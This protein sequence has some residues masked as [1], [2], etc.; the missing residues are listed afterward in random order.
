MV[1]SYSVEQ[2]KDFAST[3]SQ[4]ID[5][6][7]TSDNTTN[8]SC[9]KSK[10]TNYRV[11]RADNPED[12]MDE[13][14]IIIEATVGDMQ[15]DE[16]GTCFASVVME[17][18]DQGT[19]VVIAFITLILMNKSETAADFEV[20]SA[21]P[22]T[23]NDVN[24][25]KVTT[26]STSASLKTDEVTAWVISADVKDIDV[27]TKEGMSLVGEVTSRGLSSETAKSIL[28]T[29]VRA[30][31]TVNLGDSKVVSYG[32]KEWKYPIPYSYQRSSDATEVRYSGSNSETGDSVSIT[33]SSH[34]YSPWAGTRASARA[35]RILSGKE[36]LWGSSTLPYV[37]KDSQP[38]NYST[39]LTNTKGDISG[40]VH[41]QLESQQVSAV[42]FI[43][44]SDSS[45]TAELAG[46]TAARFSE[47]LRIQALTKSNC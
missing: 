14:I 42:P 34:K 28:T 27:D 39:L 45:V 37:V 36:E 8:C 2:S 21:Q 32:T 16:K 12:S 11:L 20:V 3:I 41:T 17:V 19:N 22:I 30:V 4:S 18:I 10:L 47:I 33:D 7:K 31:K 1:Q 9:C 46:A 13:T 15:V 24:L 44:V 29:A 38:Q 43:D 35:F 25:N 40:I 26:S 5:C 23:E 6:E